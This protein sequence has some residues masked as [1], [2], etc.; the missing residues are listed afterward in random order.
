MTK[1]PNAAKNN[2]SRGLGYVL[3]KKR[4]NGKTIISV[5]CMY[6]TLHLK[7]NENVC[8]ANEKYLTYYMKTGKVLDKFVNTTVNTHRV[9][10]EKGLPY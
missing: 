6:P 5:R 10:R 8:K 4:K 3:S 7:F 9:K 1:D 2:E